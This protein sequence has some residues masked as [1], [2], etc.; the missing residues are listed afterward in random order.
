M[1]SSRDPFSVYRCHTIMNCTKTC[2]KGLNPR[3]AIA[4]IKKLLAGL[5]NEAEPGLKGTTTVT[6]A[7]QQGWGKGFTSELS[8]NILV[9]GIKMLLMICF[10]NIFLNLVGGLRGVHNEKN[11]LLV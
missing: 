6:M 7:G 11:I 2:P 1:E 8:K 4:E 5:T 10:H 9:N 3:K